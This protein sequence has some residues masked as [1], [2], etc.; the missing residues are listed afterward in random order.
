MPDDNLFPDKVVDPT[1]AGD[2]P[3]GNGSDPTADTPLTMAAA[4]EL[5][6][7]ALSP[8]ASRLEEL[9]ATNAQLAQHIQTSGQPAAA[10]PTDTAAGE[11]FLTKFSQDPEGAIRALQQDELRQVAPMIG[12][13]LNSGVTAAVASEK[14]TIDGEFGEGAWDKL[15][16]KPLSVLLDSYKRSNVAALADNSV[17]SREVDGL[18]GRLFNDLVS[19]RDE[20]RKKTTD[21]KESNQKEL[22][23]GILQQVQTNM[24]GGIRRI[25]GGDLEITEELKGY[26]QERATAIG[27][28]VEDAKAWNERNDYGNTYEDFQAHQVKLE[29]Q[30]EKK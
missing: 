27:E 1:P 15:F 11:D 6:T 2:T 22:T 17:I 25:S 10:A 14:S 13:M 18:K 24:T 12:N 16:D 23:D 20:S 19:Y 5:I 26:L 3:S 7:Q 8:V 4:A 21:S 29:A 9:G 28:P 30:K